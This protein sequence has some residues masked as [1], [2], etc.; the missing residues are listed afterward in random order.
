MC[1]RRL[2]KN[3]GNRRAVH[4][5]GRPTMA[6][7]PLVTLFYRRLVEIDTNP[8]PSPILDDALRLLVQLTSARAGYVELLRDRE[9]ASASRVRGRS[10]EELAEVRTWIA[11]R[12]VAHS[13]S[14][15]QPALDKAS[16]SNHDE[17]LSSPPRRCGRGCCVPESLRVPRLRG[18]HD[19]EPGATSSATAA[20]SVASTSGSVTQAARMM[21]ECFM[22]DR[23][24]TTDPPWGLRS[25]AW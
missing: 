8:D 21:S 19:D 11:T 16:P 25:C 7:N 1:Q 14:K 5:R 13:I 10:A 9:R 24:A 12:P 3:L 22:L 18:G 23:T 15:G 6:S 2:R 20:C 17:R 4:A